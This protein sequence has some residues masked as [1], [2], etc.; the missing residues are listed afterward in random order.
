MRYQLP[1]YLCNYDIKRS[2]DV[3]AMESKSES[4]VMILKISLSQLFAC[5][6]DLELFNLLLF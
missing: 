6:L 4:A 5:C 1:E 3:V 2:S